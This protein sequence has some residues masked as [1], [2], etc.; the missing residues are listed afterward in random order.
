MEEDDDD[1]DDDDINNVVLTVKKWFSVGMSYIK[2]A[3][4]HFYSHLFIY[5]YVVY[6]TSLSEA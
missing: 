1:D 3:K 6:L 4:R 2:M 5:W